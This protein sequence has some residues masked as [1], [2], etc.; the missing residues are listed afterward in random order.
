MRKAEL[1]R[2]IVGRNENT[3]FYLQSEE[4]TAEKPACPFY[5]P[6][7]MFGFMD[8]EDD[9]CALKPTNSGSDKCDL[10][11]DFYRLPYRMRIR[12]K[13]NWF[14]CPLNTEENRIK[15]AGRLEEI[16]RRELKR[17]LGR[18]MEKYNIVVE[19]LPPGIAEGAIETFVERDVHMW[20]SLDIGRDIS[21]RT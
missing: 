3:T 13:P 8:P 15:L 4:E 20:V 1:I 11:T 7:A 2:K 16:E 14:G 10:K 21:K 19:L 9:R 6:S 12:D 5:G 17:E 18:Q